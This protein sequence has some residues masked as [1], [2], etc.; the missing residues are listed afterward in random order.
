[1][2]IIIWGSRIE[3]FKAAYFF[4]FYTLVGSLLL[5]IAI[6]YLYHEVG[7]T[8]WYL[9]LFIKKNSSKNI[10]IIIIIAFFIKIPLIPFHSWLPLAHVEAP[11][12]GSILLAGI[13]LKIGGYAIFRYGLSIFFYEA[14]YY[15]SIILLLSLITII[16]G[17]FLTIRQVDFKKMIAYSSVSHMGFVVLGL[18]SFSN[19]GI[20]SSFIIMLSHGFTS[21]ILFI[22]V[23]L[24]YNR[25]HTRI[26]RFYKGLICLMPIFSFFLFFTILFN[27]SFPFSLNFWGE[28]FIFKSLSK[29]FNFFFILVVVSTIFFSSIYSFLIYNRSCFGILSNNIFLARDLDKNE[30]YSLLFFFFPLVFF[31]IYPI[32]IVDNINVNIN[33]I[34]I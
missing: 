14:F 3:K 18:F 24:L 20:I 27:I 13:L 2:I 30:V 17:S 21:S 10:F 5:L 7:T 33:Y 19:I 32:F 6:L 22:L 1:M 29:T 28:L 34:L 15:K 16:Y 26:I 8:S 23:T 12:S 9:L 31:S 25:F 11:I 4:F